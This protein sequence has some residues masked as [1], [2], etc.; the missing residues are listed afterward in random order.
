M[1]SSKFVEDPVAEHIVIVARDIDVKLLVTAPEMLTVKMAE[2]S[3]E[4][5]D[6]VD[7]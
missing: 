3:D 6:D 7:F 1:W 4:F 5:E 2:Q